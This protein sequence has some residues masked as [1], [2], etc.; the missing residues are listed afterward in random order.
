[1]ARVL[2]NGEWFE[3]VA[4]TAL[5]EGEFENIFLQNAAHVFPEFH[6]VP[7]K[8]LVAS[9]FGS[10]KPDLALVDKRY[11]SWWVVEVELAHHSLTRHVLPQV[12]TFATGQYDDYHAQHL[13][14]SSVL[15][16]ASVQNMLKGQ[17]PQVMVVVN[18]PCPDW[19]LAL[20]R[21]N[22]LVTVFEIFRSRLN[23]QVFRLN[24]DQ[25]ALATDVIS[26]CEFDRSI[27]K[28]LRLLSPAAFPHADGSDAHIT[29][30]G[31]LTVWK[32]VDVQDSV[33]LI[34]AGPNP[35]PGGTRYEIITDES[36][37]LSI[38]PCP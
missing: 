1:M 36:G 23:R 18:A 15:H 9:E 24:G 16:R 29:Y 2:V 6:V 7:F 34:P 26:A 12:Q 4:P 33:W 10:Q 19:S 38:R 22:A 27:P 14:G 8:C 17:P 21:F 30:K 13:C 32:R 11:R 35:L 25:P 3:Q 20:R 31:A 28:F 5:Y 37:A